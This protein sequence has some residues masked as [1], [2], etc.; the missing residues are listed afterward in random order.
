MAVGSRGSHLWTA[1]ST[2]GCHL[3]ITI[4]RRRDRTPRGS[5]PELRFCAIRL[6]DRG[7]R[8]SRFATGRPNSA[9]RQA[10][11]HCEVQVLPPFQYFGHTGSRPSVTKEWPPLCGAVSRV[12][13]FAASLRG[14][15][16]FTAEGVEIVHG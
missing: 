10:R 16:R 12:C 7:S 9:L 3:P 8:G 4:K 15:D 13:G 1:C 2:S 6:G 5:I 11:S 14:L